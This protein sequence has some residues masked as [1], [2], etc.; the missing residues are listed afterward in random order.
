MGDQRDKDLLQAEVK[1]KVI[2]SNIDAKCYSVPAKSKKYLITSPRNVL[3][4]NESYWFGYWENQK[5]I[6]AKIPLPLTLGWYR[7][8]AGETYTTFLFYVQLLEVLLP[9]FGVDL[10]AQGKVTMMEEAIQVFKDVESKMEWC[11]QV[12][13]NNYLLMGHEY[14]FGRKIRTSRDF[15]LV[16]HFV[17]A[18]FKDSQIE[19]LKEFYKMNGGL[20]PQAYTTKQVMALASK[21]N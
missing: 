1:D 9:G 6:D 17:Y 11:L 8:K 5:R 15:R 3:I 19:I 10:E 4:Q 2:L 21:C 18:W 12:N 7:Q 20:D 16:W 13:K 14:P